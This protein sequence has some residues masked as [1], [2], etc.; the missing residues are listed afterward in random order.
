M[1][2]HRLDA[3]YW[4]ADLTFV[5]PVDSYVTGE[6]RDV[7]A[8]EVIQDENGP[9]IVDEDEL[10]A[11]GG[12]VAFCQCGLSSNKPFCDGSHQATTDEEDGVVYKYDD[13]GERQVVSDD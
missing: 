1:V 8:R 12:T 3:V 9:Y 10:E 11:Q 2:C 6:Y 4:L 5:L 13:D 7:M